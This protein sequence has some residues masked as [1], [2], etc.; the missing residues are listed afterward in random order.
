M[1]ALTAILLASLLVSA[2][3]TKK[4]CLS[5]LGVVYFNNFKESDLDS[6]TLYQFNSNNLDLPI[7]SSR[8]I[9]EKDSDGKDFAHISIFDFSK[10]YKLK[11]HLANKEILIAN[12]QT[13]NT[14]CNTCVFGNDE[15]QKLS[16]FYAN[17]IYQKGSILYLKE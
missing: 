8:V 3:C 16:G 6:I 9:A 11:I 12:F 1:R 17:N 15:Y 7:D 10:T 4:K 5:G 14:E 13:E 2:C